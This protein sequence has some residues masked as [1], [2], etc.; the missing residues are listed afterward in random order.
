MASPPPSLPL[1]IDKN[2]EIMLTKLV[3]IQIM[4]LRT[5]TLEKID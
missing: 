5:G 3:H 4:S 2:L 1:Y